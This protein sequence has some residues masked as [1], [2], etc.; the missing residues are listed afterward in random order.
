MHTIILFA[1]LAADPIE[2]TGKVVSITDGDTVKVLVGKDQ[3]TVRLDGIDAPESK[4]AFGTKSREFLA[5]LC[6]EKD[7]TVRKT[8]TDRYGRT[9]GTILV[10]GTDVNAEM[11]KAGMAWHYKQFSKDKELARLEI[12]AREAKAGLWAD[13]EPVPP[14]E[15]RK[16]PKGNA[17][18]KR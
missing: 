15:W 5:K 8:G 13:K 10:D 6:H 17:D 9:L 16:L 11:V 14:W 7:V 3:I 12:E 1:L 2:L 4:Q 18:A